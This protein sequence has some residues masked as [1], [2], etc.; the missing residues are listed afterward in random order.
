ME[1]QLEILIRLTAIQALGERKGAEAIS[2][3]GQAGL[4]AKTIAE[5]LGTTDATVRSRLS[6]ERRKQDAKDVAPA[7]KVGTKSESGEH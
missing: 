7:K 5:L 4:D 3:L 1:E 2:V 6:K